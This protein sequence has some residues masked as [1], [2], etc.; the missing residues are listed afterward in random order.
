MESLDSP[1]LIWGLS[2]A[3]SS[4]TSSRAYQT[5]SF[6]IPAQ[7]CMASRY[8]AATARLVAARCASSKPRSRPATAKLAASLLMSHSNGPGRVSSKSLRLKTRRRSGAAKIPKFDRCASPH[9]WTVRSGAG[10][11]GE[12]GG[13]QV[14]GAAEKVNGD[15][16]IR[17]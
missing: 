15:T 14:G 11:A 16:S 8:D 4:S 13:H 7:S 17:P 10:R 6:R 3:S 9:S 5:S 2:R 12:V 1:D